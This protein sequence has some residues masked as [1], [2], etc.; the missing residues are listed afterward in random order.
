MRTPGS[1]L[2]VPAMVKGIV[3]CIY[4]YLASTVVL[5]ATSFQTARSDEKGNAKSTS[6]GS[7]CPRT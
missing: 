2:I 4:I 6:T 5:V 1:M 7:F 3:V